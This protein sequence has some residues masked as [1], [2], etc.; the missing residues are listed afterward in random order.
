EWSSSSC[1]P[2][3]WCGSIHAV[4]VA[5]ESID[6]SGPEPAELRQCAERPHLACQLRE[7][8]EVAASV[9]QHGNGRAGHVG[10]RHRELGAAG[11]DPLVVALDVVGEEHGR[12]LAL[13]KYRLL[14]RF[15]RGVVVQRQL[16]LS[17]VRLLGRC[18]GQPTIWA[19]TEI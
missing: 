14:I 17:A 13:L 10:G 11:L 4:E 1:L 3:R 18:Y 5:F 16:Q 15:G 2:F 9:L 7:L 8:N 12:G 6:V 19:L